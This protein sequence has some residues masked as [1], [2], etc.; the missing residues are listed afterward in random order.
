MGIFE[1]LQW[2]GLLSDYTGQSEDGDTGGELPKLLDTQKICL[3]AGFDPTADSLHV[4]HLVP[5]LGLRRF[6]DRGHQPIALAGGATGSIGDPSGKSAERNLLSAGQIKA[7]VEAIKPQ[8]AR[9]LDFEREGNPARLVDN[10]DWFQPMGFV[11]FLRDVGKFFMVNQMVAKESVK[12]RME[13][14]GISY[15]EF[16]YMLLQ[17][18]DYFHLSEGFDC[19]LQIGGSDQW[20]N[21]VAGID[22]I[23]RKLHR[24]AYGLTMP[25]ITKADGAKFGKTESGTLWLDPARTSVYQFYQFWINTDDRD[26]SRYLR[27]FTFLSRDEIETLEAA[28][29]ADPGKREGHQALAREMTTLVH[30]ESAYRA[31]RSASS[32]LFGGAVGDLTEETMAVLRSEI[33]ETAVTADELGQGLPLLDALVATE[34][35]KSKSQARK[36]VQG[37][38]VYVN[39]DRCGDFEATLTSGD[40][41]PGGG[42][43]LRKGKRNYALVSVNGGNS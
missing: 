21:I 35:V 34:L 14:A 13:G 25:L 27:I 7:N 4:G 36:D 40:L 41:L 16:S 33:P 12:A 11:D 32:I 6:Q 2:R 5:L 29:E 20:G 30:G 10:S 18:Y 23:R 26:V 31:A 15:T 8:L 19:Q 1:D 24:P 42:I 37:G 3:Y 39:G 38:G 9:L 28:H 17:A 22:L 43:L